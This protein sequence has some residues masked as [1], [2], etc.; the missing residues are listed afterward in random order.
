MDQ[1]PRD[2]V[3]T[4]SAH[5]TDKLNL[6]WGWLPD[7]NTHLGLT[8]GT[9]ASKISRHASAYLLSWT[10]SV[11]IAPGG[12]TVVLQR[13]EDSQEFKSREEAEAHALELCKKW[14]DAQS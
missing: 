5:P 11:K 14:I 6:V 2:L 9:P 7:Q 13:L 8:H 12:R 4:H 10:Y 1:R 3:T